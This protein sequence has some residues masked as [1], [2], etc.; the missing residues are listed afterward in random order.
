MTLRVIAGVACVVVGLVWMLQGLDIVQ[1][2]FMT[3]HGVWIVFGL[4]LAGI[5]VALLI[6]ARRL[7]HLD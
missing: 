6:G 3:G 4:G 1:G 2:S 5:G 7:R